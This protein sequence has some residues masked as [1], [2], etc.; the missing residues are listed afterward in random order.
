MSFDHFISYSGADSGEGCIAEF[1]ERTSRDFE[2]FAGAPL[3]PFFDITEIKGMD[4]NIESAT[5]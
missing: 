3:H 2:S 1:V 5:H 4:A